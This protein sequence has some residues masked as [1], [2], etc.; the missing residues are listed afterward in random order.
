[1]GHGSLPRVWDDVCERYADRTAVMVKTSTG[2]ATVDFYELGMWTSQLASQLASRFGV[3]KGDN[4][5]VLIDDGETAAAQIVAMLACMRI[6]AKWVA[7]QEN[8]AGDAEQHKLKYIVDDCQPVAGIAVGLNDKCTGAAKLARLGI[9][10]VALL[11]LDGSLAYAEAMMGVKEFCPE[12]KCDAVD[13][14]IQYT[15]GTTG[16]VKGVIETVRA[17]RNRISW[18]HSTFPF[19]SSTPLKLCCKR[20][21]IGFVDSVAET[22][23]P[24]FAGVGLWISGNAE[25]KTD[26]VRLTADCDVVG[27]GSPKCV[28]SRIQMLP[29]QLRLVV[30]FGKAWDGLEY[31]F[32]SGEPVSL[33]LVSDFRQWTSG[34][35]VRLISLYGSTEVAGDAAFIELTHWAPEE[36]LVTLVNRKEPVVRRPIG[37][38]LSNVDVQVRRTEPGL[39]ALDSAICEDFEVGELFVSGAAVASRY[40]STEETVDPS[41]Q[42]DGSYRTGDLGFRDSDDGNYYW[43]GRVDNQRKVRGIRIELEQVE[44]ELSNAWGI[45]SA[46]I[47]AL[48]VNGTLLGFVRRCDTAEKNDSSLH[49]LLQNGKVLA[50]HVPHKIV[51]V[52]SFPTTSTGKLDRPALE[53]GARQILQERISESDTH[54]TIENICCETLKLKTVDFSRSFKELGGDSLLAIKLFWELKRCGQTIHALNAT[55]ILTS[56]SLDAAFFGIKGRVHPRLDETRPCELEQVRPA[57]KTRKASFDCIRWEYTM[58]RCVDAAPVTDNKYVYIGSHGFDFCKLCA[59]TG[60]QLWTQSLGGRVQSSA[61]I[62]ADSKQLL[63]ST[64]TATE[65]DINGEETFPEGPAGGCL[66]CLNS[67]DGSIISQFSHPGLLKAPPTFS[68]ENDVAWVG[69]YDA[70]VLE[71]RLPSLNLTRQVD[72]GGD[73]PGQLIPHKTLLLGATNRGRVFAISKESFQVQWEFLCGPIFGNVTLCSV[74]LEDCVIFGS[75]DEQIRCLQANNGKLL[76]SYKGDGAFF[77]PVTVSGHYV[78]IASHGKSVQLLNIKDGTPVWTTEVDAAVV[79]KPAVLK[80]EYIVVATTGGTVYL[81][82]LK[83]GTNVANVRLPAEVFSSPCPINHGSTKDIIVGSRDDK[84]RRISFC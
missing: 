12:D 29:S 80:D 6:G 51:V 28:V 8:L 61:A 82:D 45:A 74:G 2:V 39:P 36:N 15:S 10:R 44:N 71:V 73:V 60:K 23:A 76:W 17:F 67:V 5:L 49:A 55:E 65:Y 56:A 43:V 57:K 25:C 75:V 32:I 19:D 34:T 83:T 26:I 7:S 22:F 58:K 38:P 18:L 62:S 41:F 40:V 20:T 14:Y 24:L 42:P 70:K 52:D 30:K 53:A 13:L 84:V 37:K 9:H 47:C 21:P 64:Y 77:A 48:V 31:V 16:V 68:P 4:V 46:A 33:D 59:D 27:K 1:M 35:G 81:F 63:V 69:T 78:V 50:H 66:S 79:A 72:V 3:K 54:K 11:N